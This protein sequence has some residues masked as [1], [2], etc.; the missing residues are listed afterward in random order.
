MLMPT[1]KEVAQGLLDQAAQPVDLLEGVRELR[2]EWLTHQ[3]VDYMKAYGRN[4]ID[5]VDLPGL[6]DEL[7]I[8]PDQF[9]ERED[10]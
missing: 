3:I 2:R 10:G 4:S 9:G 8:D 6:L 7:G 5:D 1:S